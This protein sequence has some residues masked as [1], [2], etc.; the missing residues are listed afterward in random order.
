MA[1]KRAVLTARPHSARNTSALRRRAVPGRRPSESFNEI[2]LRYGRDHPVSFAPSETGGLR[3]AGC[4]N[5]KVISNSGGVPLR[6]RFTQGGDWAAGS[7]YPLTGRSR[8]IVE[9]ELGG[10]AEVIYVVDLAP[11]AGAV[12][13][14]DT[15]KELR[16]DEIPG[17]AGWRP[18]PSVGTR[19]V[20]YVLVH[21]ASAT[22][23]TGLTVGAAPAD[24][25]HRHT[26]RPGPHSRHPLDQEIGKMAGLRPHAIPQFRSWHGDCVIKPR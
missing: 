6:C 24:S 11:A 1:G 22:I 19:P 2:G 17:R 25:A 13:S 18:D 8:A 23:A 4:A 12:L 16:P 5:Q 20:R 9:E 7:D 15:S 26:L 10:T 21:I 3:S 14:H